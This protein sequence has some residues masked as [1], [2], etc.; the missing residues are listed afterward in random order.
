MS[1]D[2]VGG[3]CFSGYARSRYI[4]PVVGATLLVFASSSAWADFVNATDAAIG[5]YRLSSSSP[6]WADFNNDG[7]VMEILGA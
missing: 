5:T 2:E 1:R 7:L 4:G 3:R 6:S